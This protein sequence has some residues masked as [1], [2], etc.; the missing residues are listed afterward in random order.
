MNNMFY[1]KYINNLYEYDYYS[2]Q[3][4]FLAFP[5]KYQYKL[6]TI[7]N[8]SILTRDRSSMVEQ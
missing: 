4:I 2:K 1:L 6:D 5:L 7:Q 8:L 3:Y